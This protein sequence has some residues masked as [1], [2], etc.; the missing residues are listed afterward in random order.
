LRRFIEGQSEGHAPILSEDALLDWLRDLDPELARWLGDDTATLPAAGPRAVTMDSQI[1]GVHFLPGLEAGVLARRLLA[2]NLSDLA[3]AGA[4]PAFCLLSLAVPPTFDPRPFFRSFLAACADYRIQLIGGDLARSSQIVA[5]LTA[6]GDLPADHPPLR[7]SGAS[8]GDRLWV[9]GTLGESALG[10]HLLA[11]AAQ[12]RAAQGRAA[13]GQGR[14]S[15]DLDLELPPDLAAAGRRALRRHL[16]PT[17]QL[18]LGHWLIR[19]QAAAAMDISDG[20]GKDLARFC[21][22]NGLGAQVDSERLPGPEQGPSLAEN[23]GL[24]LST[25]Q[26]AGG[27]DYVLL[28]SLPPATVPPPAFACTPIGTLT[29]RKEI[30]GQG[31]VPGG[32]TSSWGWDHLAS[33]PDPSM[34]KPQGS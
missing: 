22:Q 25:L 32:P 30:G 16:L 27:E 14:L 31:A 13:Q 8:A 20:L 5:T 4:R 24:K 34:P 1:E 9:G 10:R 3:A 33:I 19:Q 15:L 21:R 12:D 23:L 6:L 7:R 26:W 11:R 28:F 2:V 18:K 29:T 17:P